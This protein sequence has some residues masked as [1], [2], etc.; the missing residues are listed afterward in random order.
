MHNTFHPHSPTVTTHSGTLPANRKSLLLA[1]T[2]NVNSPSG[3]LHPCAPASHTLRSYRDSVSFTVF[4]WRGWSITSV[5]PRST[6][7]GSPAL[8]GKCRYSCGIWT[9]SDR[10][11]AR[12]D[13]RPEQLRGQ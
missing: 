4:V 13:Q 12:G 10:G 7:G 9:D 6:L 5:K 1:P 3:F 2:E 11:E 8:S